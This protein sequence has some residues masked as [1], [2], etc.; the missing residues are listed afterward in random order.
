MT[1]LYKLEWIHSIKT[2]QSGMSQSLNKDAFMD[3]IIVC[4][5]GVVTHNKLVL[6][7]IF[8]ELR[9]IPV[10]EQPLEQ[11]LI[12][13]D[14]A[15]AEVQSLISQ[16][17]PDSDLTSA[18]LKEDDIETSVSDS[19][20]HFLETD[21]IIQDVDCSPR[22]YGMRRGRGRPPLSNTARMPPRF[23]CDYCHKGFFYRSMLT[24]HEKLHTG[25]SR[26]TCELCGAEYSTRQNL[27]NHMIK[28]HGEDS[29]TPRKRGRPPLD[30]ERRAAMHVSHSVR[31][32]GRGRPPLMTKH[33]GLTHYESYNNTTA[34]AES[35]DLSAESFMEQK[36]EDG[37]SEIEEE[38][39]LDAIRET[40]RAL[41]MVRSAELQKEQATETNIA[42]EIEDIKPDISS[43]DCSGQNNVASIS[44]KSE[45][46][47]QQQEHNNS[48]QPSQHLTAQQ[49]QQTQNTS[50]QF[51][52]IESHSSNNGS[53]SESSEREYQIELKDVQKLSILTK[54]ELVSICKRNNI[55]VT[56][57]KQA[58]AARILRK[59]GK[60]FD[61]DESP[62]M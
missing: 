53:P 38:K 30:P 10:F 6:G 36:L 45:R 41:E 59:L 55:S 3:T 47:P 62:A 29:F 31:Y 58:L 19:F 22:A 16:L 5:D 8:P 60:I 23:T 34:S 21:T 9:H 12:M 1:D 17:F 52:S 37:D 57:E 48:F 40:S 56:G 46:L 43:Q 7:L 2:I 32:R 27:K 24:A 14:W 15:V 4:Q 49:L 33:R 11:T 28:H 51:Y 26:E 13:P 61:D 25:G 18:G 44:S 50:Q 35:E 20:E 39:N 54:P 42:D